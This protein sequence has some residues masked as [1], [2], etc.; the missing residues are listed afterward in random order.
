MTALDLHYLPPTNF[1][2]VEYMKYWPDG[3]WDTC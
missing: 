1:Q 2:K 3:A